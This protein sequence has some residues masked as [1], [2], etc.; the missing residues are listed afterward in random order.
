[1][2]FG[3]AIPPA[4]DS[5]KLVKRAEELGFSYAWFYDTQLLCA[6]VFVVMAAAAVQTSRIRLGTGVLIPSNR[7]A[8]VAANALA[9]LNQLAPGRIVCGLGTGFTGRRTMGL[10]PLP[11]SHLQEYVR[12]LRQ[13]LAEQTVEWGFE[14]VPRKIRFLNPEAGLINTKD[15]IPLHISAFGPK[16]RTLA[17][18]IG[19]GWI[20]FG[21]IFPQVVADVTGALNAWKTA[22]RD[23]ATC[24][25]SIFTV[26]CILK[27]GESYDSPRVLEQAGPVAGTVYHHFMESPV[28]PH[29]PPKLA[30]FIEQYRALYNS[31][32]PE[33]ARYLTLHRGHLMFVRPDE[34]RFMYNELIRDFSFTGRPEELRE[35]IQEMK[36]AGYRQ[37]SIQV[38]PGQEDALEDWA[39]LFETV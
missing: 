36:T 21:V 9:S 10:R 32:Q 34:R 28:V 4:A 16:S 19:D 14:G 5:W 3:I 29:L 31:Y 39:K 37:F 2:D 38:I 22:G 20:N 18:Q 23:P 33:D 25:A 30:S 26:G 11:L 7:I 6:D 27:E 15:P 17:A 12:V 24:Y 1:M 8:P 13:L 35:R